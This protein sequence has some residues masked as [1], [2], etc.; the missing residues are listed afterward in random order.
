MFALKQCSYEK[1]AIRPTMEILG[2]SGLPIAMVPCLHQS[3]AYIK[4]KLRVWRAQKCNFLVGAKTAPTSTGLQA[5]SFHASPYKADNENLLKSRSTYHHGTV[6]PPK[7]CLYQKEATGLESPKMK[8]HRRC[9]NRT[10]Q[11][12]AADYPVSCI[13]V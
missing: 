7:H 8:F 13:A 1:E 11:Y 10:D 5:T 6:F 12:G 3:I 9:K 2:N 4:K